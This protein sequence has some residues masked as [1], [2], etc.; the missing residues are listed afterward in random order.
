VQFF[1]FRIKKEQERSEALL[2]NILPKSIAERLKQN[3]SAIA[4]AF[5]EATILFADIVG[6]TEI[7]GKM[8]PAQLVEILNGIFSRFDRLAEKHKLEKIKTIGDAYMVVGGLPE[9]E[10]GSAQEVLQM[11]LD[12][13]ETMKQ[14]NKENNT[15]LKIRIGVHSGP[16]IA[17]VIGL[18]KFIYDLWGDAVNVA[19]RMESTGV[20][21]RIQVTEDTYLSH[22]QNFYF[23]KRGE[24]KV[25]GKG[26]MT[27]YFLCA[28]NDV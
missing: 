13:L 17:G 7:S 10:N 11:A 6:F 3:E 25:K 14:F 23:E 9:P 12:M 8:S 5:S 27:T 18:K 22:K 16:V 24:I 21:G 20:D 15:D 1:V 26:E 28:K 2:L 19:S 4:D